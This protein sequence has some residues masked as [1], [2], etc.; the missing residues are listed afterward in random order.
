MKSHQNI[1]DDSHQHPKENHEGEPEARDGEEISTSSH[2]V[3]CIPSSPPSYY[4]PDDLNQLDPSTINKLDLPTDHPSPFNSGG[5]VW[6]ENHDPVPDYERLIRLP[7]RSDILRLKGLA[8]E[9]FEGNLHPNAPD[10]Y[11]LNWLSYED[12][13]L[14]WEVLSPEQKLNL[15][16]IAEGDWDESLWVGGGLKCGDGKDLTFPEALMLLT[17]ADIGEIVGGAGWK[18]VRGNIRRNGLYPMEKSSRR[19]IDPRAA[20]T[21]NYGWVRNHDLAGLFPDFKGISAVFS[22]PENLVTVG[23]DLFR[24]RD[25]INE[26]FKMVHSLLVKMQEGKKFPLK[27]FILSNEIS[28]RSIRRSQFNPHSHAILF[29]DRDEDFEFLDLLRDGG[30]SIKWKDEIISTENRLKNI[31]TYISKAT[32]LVEPYRRELGS[33]DLREFNVMTKNALHN[34]TALNS[35]GGWDGGENPL[36]RKF[37]ERGIP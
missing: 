19:N 23:N 25:R 1:P 9:L 36:N 31:I 32:S 28:C 20:R 16:S 24:P 7:G 34:L 29:V 8:P 13:L 12:H 2:N 3:Y 27:A 30:M 17:A 6:E 15:I 22:L 5:R 10:R 35:C 33:E 4:P 18:I 37:L 21:F 14:N 11:S 26:F